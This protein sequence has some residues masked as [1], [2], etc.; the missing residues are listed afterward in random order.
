MI[1]RGSVVVSLEQI[2]IATITNAHLLVAR[3]EWH[4]VAGTIVAIDRA[5]T[6]AVMLAPGER[7]V[8]GA[9]FALADIVVADPACIVQVSIVLAQ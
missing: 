9:L 2:C 5:A 1:E 3:W 6:T 4:L 7:K 8:S